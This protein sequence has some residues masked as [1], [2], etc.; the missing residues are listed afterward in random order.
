MRLLCKLTKCIGDIDVCH[1]WIV[2]RVEFVDGKHNGWNAQE[3]DQQCVTTGL[4]EQFKRWVFPIQFD[5]VDQDNGSICARSRGNHI[6]RVLLMARRIA[7]DELARFGTEIAVSHIDGDALFT[8]ST[9]SI[10]EQCQIS[11]ASTL[12]AS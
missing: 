2:N 7:N 12:H 9:Q 1:A 10:G 11:D 8:L 5:S 4:G 6:A 3:I